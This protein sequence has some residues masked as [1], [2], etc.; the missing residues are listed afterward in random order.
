MPVLLGLPR[1]RGARQAELRLGDAH[2]IEGVDVQDVEA[3]PPVHQ[4]L[5]EA[6]LA[7]DGIDDEWVASRSYDA[8]GM[9]PLIKGDRGLRPAEEGGDG[10]L[11]VTVPY[12]RI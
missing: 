10:R 11:G 3:A 9:V 7:D 4:H 12:A 5:S 6:L 2:G 1:G 8:G